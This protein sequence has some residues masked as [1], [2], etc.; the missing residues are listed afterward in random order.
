MT[1]TTTPL[2]TERFD[3]ALAYASRIHRTQLDTSK[4]RLFSA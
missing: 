1:E 3:D 4:N 2:L